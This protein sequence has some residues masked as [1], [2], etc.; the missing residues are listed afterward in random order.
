M[1]NG[2]DSGLKVADLVLMSEKIAKQMD[3]VV[4]S[5]EYKPSLASLQVAKSL[6]PGDECSSSAY[7]RYFQDTVYGYNY[8]YAEEDREEGH[9]PLCRTRK[10]CICE[11]AWSMNGATL[12]LHPVAWLDQ[13]RKW[14]KHGLPTIGEIQAERH[15]VQ[16]CI[17]PWEKCPVRETAGFNDW[18]TE[19]LASL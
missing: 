6:I 16:V 19:F 12:R 8:L 4:E 1:T 10:T 15:P 2:V 7:A 3:L 17:C 14:Q 13:N 9:C 11:P 18:K 5:V